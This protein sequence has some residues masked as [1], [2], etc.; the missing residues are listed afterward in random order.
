MANLTEKQIYDYLD[1]LLPSTVQ[2][3]DPYLDSESLPNTDYAVM[4]IL[5]IRNIGRSMTRESSVDE[6]E[7]TVT[8]ANDQQRIFKIQFDF[9][10]AG[11]FDNARA[12][13]QILQIKIDDETHTNKNS[14]HIKTISEIR[15]LSDLLENKK[16]LKRYGFDFELFVVDSQNITD[17]YLDNFQNTINRV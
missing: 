8:V 2:F 11:A 16:Y 15:N 14:M 12:Y 7:K 10:G 4:N 13:Q 9:Y 3:V 1:A 6:E 5:Y 17:I